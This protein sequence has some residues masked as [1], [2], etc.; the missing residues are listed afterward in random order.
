MRR[1][2]VA[3]LLLGPIVVV[4]ACGAEH[5]VYTARK[6]DADAA[7]LDPYKSIDFVNGDSVSS[8]C[9]PNCFEY[10]G[11]TFTSTM[12]PPLPDL[13]TALDA[14]A[15]ECKAAVTLYDAAC[16]GEMGSADYDSGTAVIADAGTDVLDASDGGDQ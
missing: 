9:A 10:A 2:I 5:Y 1:A 4:V 7:C 14:E 6:Y 8:T 13:A 11:E 16:G 12:C 3:A 15:P